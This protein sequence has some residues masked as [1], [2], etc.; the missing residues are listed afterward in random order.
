MTEGDLA[1]PFTKT[2]ADMMERAKLKSLDYDIGGPLDPLPIGRMKITNEV[3]NPVFTYDPALI[4]SARAT[5]TCAS[6]PCAN[7]DRAR[8]RR[9]WAR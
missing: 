8:R 3:K 7:G 2:P 6:S 9:L 1:G 5:S 4:K